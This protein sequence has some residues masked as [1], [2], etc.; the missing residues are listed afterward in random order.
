MDRNKVI[1]KYQ[2]KRG[3]NYKADEKNG[4]ETSLI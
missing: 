1:H 2:N 3:R 4:A